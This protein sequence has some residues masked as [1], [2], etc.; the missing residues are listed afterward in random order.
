MN[1]KK[2]ILPLAVFFLAVLFQPVFSQDKSSDKK[3][4]SRITHEEK[5]IKGVKSTLI[6]SEEKYDLNAN[7]IEEIDY[8]DGKVDKHLVY[9]YD[10]N[11]NKT[12]ESELD[13][14]GKVKKYS[15][16]KYENG[17]RTEKNTYDQD[18]K[19]ISKK[20]YTYTF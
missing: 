12:K 18:N 17:L 14:D 13:S 5:V 3:I 16:F 4:K 8:K 2:Y 1:T 20:I 6:D 15:E 19:L 7:L 9:E 11:N 10:T